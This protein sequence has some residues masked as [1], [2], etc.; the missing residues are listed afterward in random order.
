MK[1][2]L[3]PDPNIVK[4]LVSVASAFKLLPKLERSHSSI[5]K[6]LISTEERNLAKS[7]LLDV[8]MVGYLWKLF[9]SRTFFVLS[10]AAVFS[11]HNMRTISIMAKIV[12]ITIINRGTHKFFILNFKFY[13]IKI[14]I[15][16]TSSGDARWWWKKW[17]WVTFT[18]E[19]AYS[20]SVSSCVTPPPVCGLG[21]TGRYHGKCMFEQP[22]QTCAASTTYIF[23]RA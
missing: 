7:I 13:Y 9:L 21:V 6:N 23:T 14:I 8:V 2:R 3:Y 4:F 15:F 5:F 1:P 12:C 16:R 20:L 17:Q 11:S 18:D 19:E 22:L 10:D